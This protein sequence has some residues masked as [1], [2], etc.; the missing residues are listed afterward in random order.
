[1]FL[2]KRATAERIAAIARRIRGVVAIERVFMAS[3][4]TVRT[5]TRRAA[6]SPRRGAS[7]AWAAA[8]A[9]RA[10]RPTP[11]AL[12]DPR[13]RLRGTPWI[14]NAEVPVRAVF[15]TCTFRSTSR[16]AV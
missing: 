11:R 1:M 14:L 8:R 7:K 16:D 12:R 4:I 9:R 5:R 15:L 10:G 6:A 2:F 13:H 3:G